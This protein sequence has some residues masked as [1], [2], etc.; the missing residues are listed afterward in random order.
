MKARGLNG[1]SKASVSTVKNITYT[2]KKGDTLG[3]IAKKYN[4]TVDKLVSLNG[5][6]NKN[7]IYAGQKLKIK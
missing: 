4:T 6:K 3:G 5:I 2:V 1:L 7:L